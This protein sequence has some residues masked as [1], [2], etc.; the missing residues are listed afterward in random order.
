LTADIEVPADWSQTA[1]TSSPASISRQTGHAER[2]TSVAQ[3]VH[4]V[5]DTIADWGKQGG[6]F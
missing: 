2:E 3:L 6:Y 4:R 5:V 1:T